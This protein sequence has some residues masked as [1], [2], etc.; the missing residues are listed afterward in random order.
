M[1]LAILNDDWSPLAGA[2]EITVLEAVAQAPA[3]FA[4]VSTGVSKG[5]GVGEAS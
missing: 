2:V 5:A 4:I 3:S 1:R